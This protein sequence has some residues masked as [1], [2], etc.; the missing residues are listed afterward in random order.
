MRN[1]VFHLFAGNNY[2]Q[3]GRR[4]RIPER[5]YHQI[6]KVIES[7]LNIYNKNIFSYEIITR[8]SPPKST[9]NAPWHN[10]PYSVFFFAVNDFDL[11]NFFLKQIKFRPNF[12]SKCGINLM[13]TQMLEGTLYHGALKH[14]Q[15]TFVPTIWIQSHFTNLSEGP[16]WWNIS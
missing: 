15:R 2:I 16:W 9:L 13:N 14:F 6:M 8:T 3:T 4:I 7:S 10:V 12:Q 1:V 11:V 5:I